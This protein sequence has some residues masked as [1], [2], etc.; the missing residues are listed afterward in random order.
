MK[1]LLRILVAVSAA[2][3]LAAA[4][5]PAAAAQPSSGSAAP[6]GRTIFEVGNDAVVRPGEVVDSAIAVGGDVVVAGVVR[7]N[8]IAVGGDVVLLPTA[9]V[10]N[11]VVAVGGR[12]DRRPGAAT[13]GNVFT[14]RASFLSSVARWNVFRPVLNPLQVGSLVGWLLATLFYALAALIVAVV[15][16]RHVGIVRE[17]IER[18]FWPS[19]GWGF[20]TAL[21]VVPAVSV[22]MLLTIIGVVVLIPWLL[23]VVPLTLVFG[24]VCVSAA[25]GGRVLAVVGRP[26]AALPLAAACG[27]VLAHLVRLV[28]YAGMAAWLLVWVIGLGAVSI[29][30]WEWYRRR[31][32][33]RRTAAA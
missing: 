6:N 18:R 1:T 4:A 26:R 25:V 14:L 9:I 13:L 27:A 16:P 20:F 33:A 21:V 28:P 29:V 12:I 11:D 17:T 24:Y 23:A 32:A 31:R 5:V 19:L 15:A 7:N 22:V 10:Q 3:A 2:T 30:L 8:A